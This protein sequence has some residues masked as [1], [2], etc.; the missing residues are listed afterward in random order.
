MT[1]RCTISGGA[2]VVSFTTWNFELMSMPSQSSHDVAV[3][4]KLHSHGD[5]I[6]T[7]LLTLGV[8]LV[9]RPFVEALMLWLGVQPEPAL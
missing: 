3:K 5:L 1:W 9:D 4:L 8:D 2:G 6:A 7:D